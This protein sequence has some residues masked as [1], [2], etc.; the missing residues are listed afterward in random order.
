MKGSGRHHNAQATR[1]GGKAMILVANQRRVILLPTLYILTAW[2]ASQ[3][4]GICGGFVARSHP[5]MGGVIV[6]LYLAPGLASSYN[7]GMYSIGNEK[8]PRPF[9]GMATF[10]NGAKVNHFAVN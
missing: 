5:P 7:V 4:S 2:V 9:P 6:K 3:I 1:M 10:R 8:S